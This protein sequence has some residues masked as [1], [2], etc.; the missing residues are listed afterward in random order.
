VAEEFFDVVDEQDKP[1]RRATRREVHARGLLHR[2]VHILV[3]DSSGKIFLQ[4][5][6]MKKDLS[7]GLWDSSCSGHLDAGEDY[8]SAAKRELFE[9][10]GWKIEQPLERW[11]RIEACDATG[12]EFVWVY[13]LRS[14]GPFQLDPEE[15]DGGAWL[16]VGEL[17]TKISERPEDYCSAFRLVWELVQSKRLLDRLRR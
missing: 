12:Q 10:L 13:G 8:D 14:D 17:N 11:L 9:E 7:P 16:T 4:K 6:S 3:F 1:V 2:A 15:I 5:R